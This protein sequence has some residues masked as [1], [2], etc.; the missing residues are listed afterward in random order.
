MLNFVGQDVPLE[1][2]LRDALSPHI[3]QVWH[4]LRPRGVVD[5]TAGGPLPDRSKKKFS[6]GVRAEPQRENASIEPVH[7]P[8]RLDQLQG[9]LV[10]RDGHVDFRATSRP[11]T[12]RSRSPPRALAISQPD[13]RWHMHFDDL[14]VDRLRADRELIQALP[15]RLKKAVAELN[16]TGPINLRGSFDL[17]RSGRPGE[18]LRSQWDVRLGL[19]QASLQCGGL[20]L[21]NV[22]GEVSLRGGFDGQQRAIARRVGP[23]FAELQG[24]SAHA[25]HGTDL[26]RRRP[27]AVRLL[28]RSAGRRRPRPTEATGPRAA[29]AVADG[30]PLRRH[31]LRRRLGDAGRRTALCRERHVDRRRSGPLAQE[32]AHRPAETPRQDPRHGRSDRQRPHPQRAVRPRHDPPF[33]RPTSTNC[34]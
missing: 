6:V 8:Y 31:A 27:G 12:D 1:E 17:E 25:G 11:S 18:P 7:F 13:G 20:P 10:Y 19:Q 28:G 23:R 16:P 24:L 2:D 30:Q 3:Q 22:C 21:E 14:S 26:D 32:F 29:A 34:R 15:E 5:L 9:V 4:D 33:R